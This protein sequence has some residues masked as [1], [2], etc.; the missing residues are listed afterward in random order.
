M[1]FSFAGLGYREAACGRSNPGTR[2]GANACRPIGGARLLLV[3]AALI[4]AACAHAQVDYTKGIFFNQNLGGQVPL[5]TQLRDE[6]GKTIRLGDV[7][8][9]RP[10]ILVPIAFRCQAACAMVTDSLLKTLTAMTGDLPAAPGTNSAI[11]SFRQI[12]T[13]ARQQLGQNN[14]GLVGRDFDVVFISIDPL[15]D[16]PYAVKHGTPN[17]ITEQEAPPLPNDGMVAA[18]KKDLILKAY[19]QPASAHGW[20][21]LTGTLENVHR[22]TDAIGLGY[23]FNPKTDVIRN[24]TGIVFLTP[25]GK[26]S[27]YL[28]GAEY[29]TSVLT[30]DL[31]TAGEDAIGTPTEKIMFVCFT[32]DPEAAKHTKFIE[33]IIRWTCLATLLGVISMIVI[34]SLPDWRKSHGGP[35]Q[36]TKKT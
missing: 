5:D 21:L 23:Y 15:D 34:L 17:P 26:I 29:A 18:K 13:A 10:V 1:N 30:N 32:P 25:T 6:S 33:G 16:D 3:M 14:G 8:Q 2:P 4:L 35:T 7:F 24:P 20:H 9:G 31:K 22:V 27:S 28:L 11:R 36:P 12:T 19:D